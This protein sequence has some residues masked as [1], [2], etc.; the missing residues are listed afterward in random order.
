VELDV[1]MA[2]HPTYEPFWSTPIRF[3]KL[4]RASEFHYNVTLRQGVQQAFLTFLDY[5][6]LDRFPGL[7]LGILESGMGWLGAF[8]DRCDAVFD[9]ISGRAVPIRSKPSEIFARQCF[10]SGDPDETAAPL[11]FDHVGADLFVWATDYPHP[12]HPSTWVDALT[13]QVDG[14]SESTRT[15]YLG[16]NVKRIYRLAP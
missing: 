12:D 16:D 4:G 13:K 8:L 2:I 10:I 6:T 7:R 9:T 3:D 11:L 15:A 1:P 5:G 14:L